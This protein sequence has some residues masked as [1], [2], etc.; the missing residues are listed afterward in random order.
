MIELDGQAIIDQVFAVEG[1]HNWVRQDLH[2][3]RGDHEITV[4]APE[5]GMDMTESFTLDDQR[6]S[7]LRADGQGLPPSPW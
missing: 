1:Q 5:H 4:T 7:G 6:T 3:G 2:V